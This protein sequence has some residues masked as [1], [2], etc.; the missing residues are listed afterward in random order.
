L[1][2]DRDLLVP[3]E[4]IIELISAVK[5]DVKRKESDHNWCRCGG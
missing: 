2:F 5:M 3:F 1:G 4:C